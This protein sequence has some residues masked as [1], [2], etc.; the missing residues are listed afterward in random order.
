MEPDGAVAVSYAGRVSMV[1]HQAS[2]GYVGTDAWVTDAFGV[3]EWQIGPPLYL[4]RCSCG[5][6]AEG[7]ADVRA[8]AQGR[9]GNTAFSTCGPYST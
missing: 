5:H 3:G 2:T 9:P 8:M 1:L 4:S 7:L 6:R